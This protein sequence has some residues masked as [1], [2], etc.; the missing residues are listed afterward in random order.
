VQSWTRTTAYY[1][2]FP[3]R[4][5]WA[6]EG[7]GATMTLATHHLD[8]FYHLLGTPARVV[9]WTRNLMHRVE[10]EDTVHALF[11]WRDGA[12]GYLHIS[13]GE[14]GTPEQID[15]VGTAGT[16]SI[17]SG[18][19]TATR[20]EHDLR[21][22]VRAHHHPEAVVGVTSREVGPVAAAPGHRGIYANLV[23]ALAGRVPL[24]ADGRE[25]RASLE[26]ANALLYASATGRE[27][28]LPLDPDA[29]A[30]FLARAAGR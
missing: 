7:G 21:E 20:F 27:V 1:A 3:W 28:E 16:L 26:L 2:N 14:A 8:L 30:A 23:D 18:T 13:S 9:G 24:V 12:L 10:T 6:H 15:I 22:H 4:G 17:G 5:T 19:L 29:Y 25:G 11:E